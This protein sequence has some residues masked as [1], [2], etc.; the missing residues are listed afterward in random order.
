MEVNEIFLLESDIHL[1]W[2]SY[3]QNT[4]HL[5]TTHNTTCLQNMNSVQKRPHVC[6]KV[7]FF[8]FINKQQYTDHSSLLTKFHQKQNQ[9][10]PM[11]KPNGVTIKQT[12]LHSLFN[13]SGLFC[14]LLCYLHLATNHSKISFLTISTFS[15]VSCYVILWG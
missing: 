12:I 5:V 2:R 3:C 13:N 10:H 8:S 7:T 1:Q 14:F 15:S 9:I 6:L 4:H 11:T